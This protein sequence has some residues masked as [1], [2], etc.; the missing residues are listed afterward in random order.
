MATFIGF[1]TIGQHKKFTLTDVDLVKR[2][3][4]NAL[5]INKGELPGVPDYGTTIWSQVFNGQTPETRKYIRDEIQR[6][7]DQDT[8]LFLEDIEFYE[9][10]NGLRIELAVRFLPDSG[11]ERLA[12]FFDQQSQRASVV[13]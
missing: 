8:R 12:I 1:N 3:L 4:V 11:A 13:S 9:F 10:N 2:D 5:N 6:I 7:I